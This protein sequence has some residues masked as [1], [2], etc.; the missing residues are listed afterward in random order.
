MATLDQI[1]GTQSR[2]TNHLQEKEVQSKDTLMKKLAEVAGPNLHKDDQAFLEVFQ[3]RTLDYGFRASSLDL[4]TSQAIM[5][6]PDRTPTAI[7]F[8]LYGIFDE[9]E[10][11]MNQHAEWEP[12]KIFN[13]N[14]AFLQSGK[15][16][17][18]GSDKPIINM[19]ANSKIGELFSSP[20][21]LNL[22]DFARMML[23]HRDIEDSYFKCVVMEVAKR[24]NQ[25]NMLKTDELPAFSIRARVDI[26]KTLFPTKEDFISYHDTVL[27]VRGALAVFIVNSYQAIKQTKGLAA[28][29]AAV[30][31]EKSDGPFPSQEQIG[32]H[33]INN[34]NHYH[35]RANQI[36]G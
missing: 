7:N 32:A 2:L 17:G 16:A 13:P 31:M 1:L 29:A 23:S 22:N 25:I 5:A 15:F 18:K 27:A 9:S 30:L 12:Y 21:N 6:R 24:F 33:F 34:M 3:L 10:K 19:F 28:I 35:T 11:K 4:A 14:Y 36:Y 8:T 26:Y 20:S